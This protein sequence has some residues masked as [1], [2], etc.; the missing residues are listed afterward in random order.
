MTIAALRWAFFALGSTMLC[1]LPASSIAKPVGPGV[2]TIPKGQG[3]V[4][5]RIGP[6]FGKK[7]RSAPLYIWRFD[8]RLGELMFSGSR[9]I[10]PV[11]KGEPMGQQFGLK[12][13][14]AG[15]DKSVFLAIVSPGEYVIHGTQETCFC[16]GTYAFTVAPDQV[17][18]LGTVLIASEGGR[19]AI[20]ELA[21]HRLSADLIDRPFTISSIALVVPFE[22]GDPIPDMGMNKVVPASYRADVRFPNRGPTRTDRAGGLLINRLANLP[23]PSNGDGQPIL[24]AVQALPDSSQSG[25][26]EI[27]QPARK[28]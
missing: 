3:A 12:P 13:Y 11:K 19:G 23:P 16:L 27:L 14:V 22:D 7:A 15:F 6:V 18:D 28:R 8:R 10:S 5:V 24:D 9:A 26:S 2:L 1:A 17:I 20:P 21:S 4:L 25:L